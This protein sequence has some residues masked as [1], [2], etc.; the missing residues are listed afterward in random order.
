MKRHA[1]YK[2]AYGA[3]VALQVKLAPEAFV[4]TVVIIVGIKLRVQ[5]PIQIDFSISLLFP[6][7]PTTTAP[8]SSMETE[9]CAPVLRD[10]SETL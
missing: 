10:R 6:S 9:A 8:V 3:R 4:V 1:S 2:D 5:S 7:A